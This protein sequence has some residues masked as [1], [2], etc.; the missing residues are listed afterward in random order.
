MGFFCLGGGRAQ[1]QDKPAR[2]RTYH[3]Y[4]QRATVVDMESLMRQQRPEPQQTPEADATL[5]NVMRESYRRDRQFGFRSVETLAVLPTQDTPPE[6]SSTPTA[7]S[8]WLRPADV[9]DSE[10]IEP[11]PEDP[12]WSADPE[13]DV[14]QAI[15]WDE[16]AKSLAEKA[17]EEPEEQ[18]TAKPEEEKESETFQ[19]ERASL[20]S[21]GLAL[22]PVMGMA[23]AR[24]IDRESDG[25]P[26]TDRR[27]DA[28]VLGA[29]AMGLDRTPFESAKARELVES[30][31]RDDLTR[32]RMAMNEITAPWQ[33]TPDTVGALA[34]AANA[35]TWTP[36]RPVDVP[37]AELSANPAVLSVSRLPAM[38]ES[39]PLPSMD[40]P[41]MPTV[42]DPLSRRSPASDPATRSPVAQP[43][44]FRRDEYRIRPGM[45]DGFPMGNF[46]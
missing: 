29:S 18:A 45:G 15:P 27:A 28:R 31:E 10:N 44:A 32:T 33:R 16:L 22:A 25:A 34:P 14:D 12:D 6:T 38:A 21:T 19:R 24:G 40:M 41:R 35:S 20:P 26:S 9:A 17:L 3:V 43:P 13:S 2:G 37:R 36:T 7:A 42:Q 11:L 5:K 8:G 1:A 46:R 30:Y 39:R 23:V 4:D